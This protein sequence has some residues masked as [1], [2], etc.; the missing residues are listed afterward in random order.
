MKLLRPTTELLIYDSLFTR[1][2][3][4]PQENH[5]YIQLQKG[6][7]GEKRLEK[8]FQKGN[9]NKIAALFSNL[10]EYDARE[11]QIDC[12]L[13]TSDAIYLLEVKNYAGNFTMR[14]NNL[15]YLETNREITNPLNQLKRT[16]LLF[17][18]MLADLKINIQ[19]RSF[20]VFVN[21]TFVLYNASENLP[22]VLP[23]QVERFFQKIN[24]NVY[25]LTEQTSKITKILMQQHKST[26][27]FERRP[28][29]D[30]L[31]C[32]RGLFCMH[33]HA[34]LKRA[35]RQTFKCKQCN[36]KSIA[37]KAVLYAIAQFHLLFPEKKITI[38]D[39]L[40]WCG[41]MV[42]EGFMRNV[43]K[44]YLE[45]VPKSK[46]TYYYFKNKQVPYEL[47]IRKYN[48]AK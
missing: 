38:G 34:K 45:A 27:N 36:K 44:K 43:F 18:N 25:T 8:L 40:D 16:E 10:Y 20:I 1:K 22:I 11:F 33:C 3:L 2:Q 47:L 48:Q 23:P 12:T 32:R 46:Y 28:I 35:G 6:Y 19:V 9:Y 13:I 29:Y 37:D 30:I 4:S 31:D 21:E 39:L 5:R 15:Y 17:K 26:S 41:H 14:N 7:E 24:Q 42:S